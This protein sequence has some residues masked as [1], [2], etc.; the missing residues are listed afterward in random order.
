MGKHD[1][2]STFLL[3]PGEGNTMRWSEQIAEG[4]QSKDNR[5]QLWSLLAIPILLPVPREQM[6]QVT[7]YFVSGLAN[8]NA[9]FSSPCKYHF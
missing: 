9:S 3:S 6:W 7:T 4:P 5:K 2:V 8:H 1:K